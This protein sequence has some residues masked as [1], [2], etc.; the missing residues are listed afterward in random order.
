MKIAVL[1]AG[2]SGLGSAYILSKKH[3]VDLY[4]KEDR[5]GGH[6]R[7]SMVQDEDKVFGVDTGFLVFNHPTY[8]LLTKLFKELDVKI[9][10][11][12]MSFAFWD[13]DINRA[14]NGSSLKGMFAQKRNLFSLTH[15]KMIKDIL[16]FNKKANQDLKEC[17]SNLDKTLGE[18]IKDYSNAFKQRYLLPMGAAIW[19][20]PSDE[21]NNFPART[22]LTFFKNH[23]LLGVSTHHQWLTVSNGSINYV[24]KIKNE[25]SGKIFVN[26]DVIKVQR[27]ENGIFLIHRN[28]TKSFYDKV[29]L[30]M[31]A[32]QAL[33]ILE[34]P[35][36]K[37]IEILSAFKY[38]ENSAVLHND[39]NI[40]YPNRKMYAAWNYTSSNKQNKLVTLSYWINTLQNLKTK[41]DYFVSLNETQNINNV[42]EKISYEHPQFD[43]TA[44]KMQ[45]RKDEICGHNNT[46]FAGAYWR[47]GFH[48]DGLL[49]ATKVASKLGC[50]F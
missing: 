7:T 25:I 37:E 15:Y 9:E 12:D 14:Y 41:K 50:E 19:S 44:I 4:E 29:I 34:N 49:S 24:N 45:S 1:G 13:K 2:I 10:N 35:T 31:H 17:N 33:E 20:T 22:F 23:G 5:L 43:S 38:K 32:P 3:E 8:P 28:G 11:S 47:Y 36:P 46:Y 18:Y 30:A 40:L 27:E 42:I 26:S 48:E 6:A 39:N 16:D 21:M